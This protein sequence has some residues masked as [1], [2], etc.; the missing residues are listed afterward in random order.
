MGIKK[1]IYR[2]AGKYIGLHH[3]YK[4]LDSFSLMK[5]KEM[6]IDICASC[7]AACPFCPREYMPEGRK[8]GY[9]EEEIF[10]KCISEAKKFNIKHIRL[11]ANAEPTLHPNFELFINILKKDNFNISVSTNASSLIKNFDALSKVD[12]LQYS[13]EGWNQ[14]TYEKMRYPLKF[15]NTYEQIRLFWEK[16]KDFQ[17]RPIIRTNLLIT[18]STDIGKYCSLW[19]PFVDSI[20]MTPL[21]QSPYFKDGK[22]IGGI[23]DSISDEYFDIVPKLKKN[24]FCGYPF[25]VISISFDGKAFLCCSDFN[26]TFEIGSI[27]DGIE[28]IFNSEINKQV[29]QQFYEQNITVCEGCNVFYETIPSQVRDIKTRIDNIDSKYKNKV[30]LIL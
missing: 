9:M 1:N 20:S 26:T 28:K 22:M 19:A 7:N 14:E 29:R 6:I 25:S 27:M 5:P 21:K 4:V 24:M 23:A 13:I 16:I 2:A 18:K 17:K 10:L 11:F 8:K 15:D 3:I 12:T 30:G